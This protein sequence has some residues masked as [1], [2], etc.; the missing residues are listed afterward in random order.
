MFEGFD[1]ANGLTIQRLMTV[2]REKLPAAEVDYAVEDAL[3]DAGYKGK[4]FFFLTTP[5]LHDKCKGSS[6][7]IDCCLAIGAVLNFLIIIM[8]AHVHMCR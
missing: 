4:H 2:L 3:V 5:L 6:I 8:R 1:G 7:L